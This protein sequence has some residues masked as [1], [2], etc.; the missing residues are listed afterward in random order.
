MQSHR[1]ALLHWR[2]TKSAAKDQAYHASY[3]SMAYA[4]APF[5]LIFKVSVMISGADGVYSC[6]LCSLAVNLS[7]AQVGFCGS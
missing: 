1:T 6:R 7:G 3:A 5:D 4:F 2:E